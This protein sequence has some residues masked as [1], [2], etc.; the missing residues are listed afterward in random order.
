[1]K[2]SGWRGV[3]RERYMDGSGRKYSVETTRKEVA[4][5]RLKFRKREEEWAHGRE[6][7]V[8]PGDFMGN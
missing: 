4:K 5:K 8:Y 7:E 2:E 6:S 3:E 1:M